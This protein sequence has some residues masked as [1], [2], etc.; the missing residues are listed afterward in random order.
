MEDIME[1]TYEEERQN[2]MKAI[3][4][5]QQEYFEMTQREIE[6]LIHRLSLLPPARVAVLEG[7][8][9]EFQRVE[10]WAPPQWTPD[11]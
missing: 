7:Q 1:D 6:P 2:I 11:A 4:F 3:R 8:I 9:K 5:I 10:K